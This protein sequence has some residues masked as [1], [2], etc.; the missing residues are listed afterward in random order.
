MPTDPGH[1]F[2]DVVQ[3]L[4]GVNAKYPP[5]G[6]YPPIDNS[7]F[8]AN[9][10]TSRSESTGLPTHAEIGDIMKCFDTAKQLPVIFQLATEFAVCDQWFSSLPGPTWPNRFFVH[11]AS[12]AGLDHSPS[13]AQ[14]AEWESV[15]GF[16]YPRG[17]LFD[18]LN[19][20][21]LQWRLYRD[22]EGPVVGAVPQVAS[23]KGLSLLD[24]HAFSGFASD[25][26]S[27]YNF[28]YTFI[29]PNYGEITNDSYSGGSS[30]H[31]MDGVAGGERLI[32]ATY[33]AIRN[34][35]LWHSSMLIITYD[36]HGGFYDSALP[37][38]V[39][40]PTD[41]SPSTLNE[42]G[43]TFKQYGVRVPAV[44]VSPLIPKGV[45]DHTVYDHS[46]VPATLERLFGFPAL[47][48]RDAAAN[49]L[50]HLATLTLATSRT[51]CPTTLHNPAS[52]PARAVAAPADLSADTR[53]VPD[54]GNVPGFLG[55]MLKTELELSV[56][57]DA[58]KAAIIA[59]FQQIKTRGQARD[60]IEKVNAKLRKVQASRSR[61]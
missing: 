32:K 47:T 28:Q 18:A 51:D 57:G 33:E 27:P 10:A 46:S 54:V 21:K 15:S 20:A 5:G 49:D 22:T 36:E 3:Q 45:V 17:S 6:A 37:G 12:S 50:R 48:H 31:P 44:A 24:V 35:P 60:Y 43:F 39:Q 53:P 58:E 38:S 41:G 30:Q 23:L 34:S 42:Y 11:G 52:A 2:L 1:E 40:A 8:A 26:Q 61:P 29:E 16:V 25:L 14:I 19:N 7:G 13:M 59:N 9:Y 4:A 56:G 55:V